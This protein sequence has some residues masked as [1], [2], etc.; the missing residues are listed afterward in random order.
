M[1]NIENYGKSF[2]EKLKSNLTELG[3]T[4]ERFCILLSDKYS[5]N[6]LPETFISY[7]RKRKGFGRKYFLDNFSTF[8]DFFEQIMDQISANSPTVCRI[9]TERKDDMINDLY[10]IHDQAV[11]YYSHH[12]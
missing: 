12:T 11:Q 4:H 7:L 3:I 1:E 5:G 10:K 9:W 8:M 2:S 6:P